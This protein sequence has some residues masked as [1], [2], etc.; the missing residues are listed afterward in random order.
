MD[1]KDLKY[2]VAVY[3]TKSF[4]RAT[5]SLNTVPS[6]VSTRIRNLEA[7]LGI[8]LFERCYHHVKPTESANK[9]YIR[10]NQVIAEMERTEQEFGLSSGA[11]GSRSLA[12]PAGD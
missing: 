8:Q 7:L 4:S 1:I 6:N 10:A 3:E 9:L 12:D 5:D 2:F 11:R